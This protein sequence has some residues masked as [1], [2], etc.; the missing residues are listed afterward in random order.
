MIK[1]LLQATLFFSFALI[2]N[3]VESQTYTL[4]NSTGTYSDLVSPSVLDESNPDI[5]PSGSSSFAVY[6]PIAIGFDFELLGVSYDSIRIAQYGYV[7]LS[8]NGAQEALI[9]AYDCRLDYFQGDSSLSAINYQLEGTPGSQILKIEFNNYGFEE[10]TLD[11]Y[12][13]NFQLWLFE[14]CNEFEIH[15]GSTSVGPGIFLGPQDAAPL[16]GYISLDMGGESAYL[17]GSS[18]APVLVASSS[19]VMSD[20]PSSGTIYNFSDCAVGV[21]ESFMDESIAIYPNPVDDIIVI[22]LDASDEFSEVIVRDIQ[23]VEVKRVNIEGTS[24]P[25]VNITELPAAVYFL[26]L[27]STNNTVTKRII[28]K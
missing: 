20:H 3:S 23:G 4:T 24:S 17:S 12:F 25:V 21:D 7:K 2:A 26:E 11:Q 10:D 9:L 1:H 14:D 27:H 19:S 18:S 5:V 16:M 13:A 22:D 8:N 15:V 6:Q 28:K